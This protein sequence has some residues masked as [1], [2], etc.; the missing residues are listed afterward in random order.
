VRRCPRRYLALQAGV[1]LLGLA[2]AAYGWYV[3][4]ELGPL[5]F[6]ST[7]TLFLMAFRDQMAY[8]AL[9]LR[10]TRIAD[11]LAQIEAE[12]R[13]TVEQMVELNSS[14]HRGK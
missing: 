3:G 12:Y 14:P 1:V 6:F 5:S 7:A 2:S 10:Y 4:H 9:C 8:P 11:T 13:A